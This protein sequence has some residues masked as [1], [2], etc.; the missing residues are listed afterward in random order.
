MR[1]LACFAVAALI[2]APARADENDDAAQAKKHYVRGMAHYN[3][4]EFDRAIEEFEA[5]YRLKPDPVF[6]YN[7]AQCYRRW[8]KPEQALDFYEKY[9]RQAHEPP[10]RAEV[11]QRIRDLRKLLKDAGKVESTQPTGPLPPAGEHVEEPK[12]TPTVDE[13]AP[14]TTPT[15][16]PAP[17]NTAE[18][19]TGATTPTTSPALDLTRA[20]ERPLYKRAWLWATVAAAVVVVAVAV[21][22][23]VVFG[24]AASTSE[25][26]FPDL[27]AQ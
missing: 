10:N 19:T 9:L 25:H 23:G 21:T 13:T 11:Q 17:T 16:T 27:M 18:P 4:D 5:G 24:A 3:L 2:A 12:P 15:A 8:K 26:A 22:L 7:V 14:T 20:P 1:A 6:L